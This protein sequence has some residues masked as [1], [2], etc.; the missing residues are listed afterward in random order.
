MMGV[1][2]MLHIVSAEMAKKVFYK[3][4]KFQVTFRHIAQTL[5]VADRLSVSLK[6]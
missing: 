2:V 1:I 4:V 3:R 6:P 5:T